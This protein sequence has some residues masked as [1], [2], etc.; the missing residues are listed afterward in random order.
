[1]SKDANLFNSNR[2]EKKAMFNDL[3]KPIQLTIY[4]LLAQDNFKAAKQLYDQW[5][6]KASEARSE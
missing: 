4:N 3:P 2:Q 6:K 1:M 5:V